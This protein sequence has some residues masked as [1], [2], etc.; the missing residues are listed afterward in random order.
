MQMYISAEDAVA[1]STMY[2]VN[3]TSVVRG[4]SYIFAVACGND[5]GAGPNSNSQVY[6]HAT[7]P[8][9]ANIPSGDDLKIMLNRGDA[10]LLKCIYSDGFPAESVKNEWEKDGIPILNEISESLYIQNAVDAENSGAY[11]CIAINALGEARSSLV[12]VEV[13]TCGKGQEPDRETGTCKRC[14][15]NCYKDSI[16]D[17]RCR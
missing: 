7:P 3:T 1:A 4:L 16:G 12:E 9:G 17:D 6:V 5:V 10:K 11:S 2:S 15:S 14:S 8:T 13:S